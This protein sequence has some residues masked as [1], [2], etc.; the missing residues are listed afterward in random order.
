VVCGQP[1][2][3]DQHTEILL[4]PSVILEVLSPA[5]EAFDRGE[6]FQRYQRWNPTLTDYLLVSQ[7]RAQVEHFIRQADG[8]W[9][10]YVHTGLDAAV[11]IA[12]I[13]CTLK[14]ADV[15]DRVIFPET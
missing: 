8:G 14:L 10:Q 1:E 7:D 2:Y 11:T 12:S 9:T 3:Q 4:N 15:Y 13:Q 6:K 5:T